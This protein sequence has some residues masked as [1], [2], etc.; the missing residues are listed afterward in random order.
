MLPINLVDKIVSKKEKPND[1]KL[2]FLIALLFACFFSSNAQ[3]VKDQNLLTLKYNLIEGYVDADATVM[4]NFLKWVEKED[5]MYNQVKGVPNNWKNV[6]LAMILFDEP[7]YYYQQFI[8]KKIDSAAYALKAT[9]FKSSSKHL[10]PTQ[11]KCYAY[12]VAGL[13]ESGEIEFILDSNNDND[14]KDEE[15]FNTNKDLASRQKGYIKKIAVQFAANNGIANESVPIRISYNVS[16]ENISQLS[17]NFPSHAVST[18][19]KSGEV[20]DI[21]FSSMYSMSMN[22][23]GAQF[24]VKRKNKADM[25][26]EQ[27]KFIRIGDEV[28]E[29]IGIDIH[30]KELHLK[31]INNDNIS[32]PKVGFNAPAFSVKDIITNATL[33]LESYKGKYVLID[34]WATWC[35]PC[36]ESLLSIK[37]ASNLLSANNVVALAVNIASKDELKKV[38]SMI[39]EK[40]FIGNQAYSDELTQTFKVGA[41][42]ANF[43]ISPEGKIVG[44]DIDVTKLADVFKKLIK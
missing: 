4:G 10:I 35:P 15:L 42:P 26:V 1:M 30:A 22:F 29:N 28:Y 27:E 9:K 41:I 40:G 21:R 12:I 6:K 34:F 18:L 37:T 43:L 24:Y 31:K 38:K 8:A 39:T 44:K 13:N 19:E 5:E 11:I 20:Y 32:Y 14:F 16:N 3:E 17:Y 36:I 23:L 2:N 7:Q 25:A 33:S